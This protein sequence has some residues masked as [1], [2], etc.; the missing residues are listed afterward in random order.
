MVKDSYIDVEFNARDSVAGMGDLGA[1][2]SIVNNS[3]LS[4][5]ELRRDASDFLRAYVVDF[6]SDDPE[7]PGELPANYDD[8]GGV[9]QLTIYS[10]RGGVINGITRREGVPASLA[11][12]YNNPRVH[13]GRAF[14]R[15][16]ETTY[17][18]SLE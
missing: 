18:V 3:S 2:V 13:G 7:I 17:A 9:R 4:N 6:H 15:S 8:S 11:S 10:P 12:K 16:E 1:V 14:I 5:E